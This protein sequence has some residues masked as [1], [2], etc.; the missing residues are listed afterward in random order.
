M[1]STFHGLELGKR[2][3]NVGQAS[4]ATTGHNIANANTKGYSRQQVNTTTS[5][6]LDVWT[7]GAVNPSQLGSGVSLDSITRVRDRFLDQ[8]YR[9]QAGT[10][11]EWSVKQ[12]TLDRL[13]TAINEP[14]ETGLRFAMDQLSGAWQDLANDP[15]SPSAQAVLKE[16]AEAFVETAQTMDRAMSN[17]KDDLNQQLTATT[18]EAN[19][20]L[21][22]IAELN[23]SILRSGSQSN[24][25][26]DKRD[27][28]VEKLSELVPIKV[29]AQTNGVYNITLRN[30][31]SLVDGSNVTKIDENSVITGG[32][33]AG[34]NESLTIVANY[35]NKLNDSVK[36]FAVATGMSATPATAGGNLFIGDENNFSIANLKVN[37]TISKD[38]P[39]VLNQAGNPQSAQD[40]FQS[41][42]G[43]LG[44]ESQSAMNSIANHE[45]A[46]MA[47]E[48]HRQSVSGVSLDEEMANLIKYQHSYS[49]AA[50]MISTTDQMLD[51]IINRMAAR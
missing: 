6:S 28:L 44:A 23:T 48:S 46:L 26:L 1:V 13:E 11:G 32:K 33:L 35:Q 36:E 39:P 42:V 10:L 30:G 37:S 8:Q 16:R 47:T 22:Q 43:E 24:D 49:A 21:K 34:I 12:Q 15:S 51:T 3:L 27:V 38:N 14:S 19:D 9:D 20:Y 29:N 41:L 2:G 50:R 31:T 7:S 40:S 45:A 4:I 25:L 5:P 17:V 18:D